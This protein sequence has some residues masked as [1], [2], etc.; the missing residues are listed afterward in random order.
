[1]SSFEV[2]ARKGFDAG[3]GSMCVFE[4]CEFPLCGSHLFE[5]PM[6]LK[7]QHGGQFDVFLF[8]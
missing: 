7:R 3:L 8:W 6:P 2:A 5:L 1:M 4:L